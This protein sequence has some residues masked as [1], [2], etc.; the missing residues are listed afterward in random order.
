MTNLCNVRD[1]TILKNKRIAPMDSN[2]LF[3]SCEENKED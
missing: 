1:S 3:L 2:G